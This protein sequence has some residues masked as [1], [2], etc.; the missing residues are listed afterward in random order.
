MIVLH[1][2][3]V[4]LPYEK[5]VV[6]LGVFDGMHRAHVRIISSAVRMA[7][8][9]GAPCV[10]VTFHPHPHNERQIYS[11]THRLRIIEELGVDICFVAHFSREFSRI[12]AEVFVEQMLCRLL[13]ASDVYVGGNFRF[14]FRGAGS[15]ALLNSYARQ[16]CFKVHSLRLVRR[17]SSV[18]SSTRI[19]ELISRGMIRAAADLLGRRVSIY[20]AVV[21]GDSL[22]RRLGFPTANVHPH[23]D[24]VP[25]DGVYAVL[26]DID[27]AMRRGICNI[28]LRPTVGGKRRR[29]VEVHLF[30]FNGDLYHHLI[31]VMFVSRIRRE[32][33][34]PSLKKLQSQISKDI[35]AA[36]KILS[37]KL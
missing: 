9:C 4:P 11:L 10:V 17:G 26:V 37:G 31:E 24:I 23:H 21:H 8:R 33:K 3:Q 19:R 2:L 1:S 15:V 30:D 36:R 7:R 22:G 5:T 25:A 34:F 20:G 16:G 18:I 12:P 35:A 6:A 13:H 28:G 27:G 32:K 29:S 14:G